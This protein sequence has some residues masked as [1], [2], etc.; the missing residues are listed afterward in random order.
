L[1]KYDQF[2]RKFD[3]IYANRQSGGQGVSN[4]AWPDHGDSGAAKQADDDDDL[5]S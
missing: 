4:F 5:Y 2:R 3:P 1:N